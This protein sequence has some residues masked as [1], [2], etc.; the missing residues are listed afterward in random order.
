M[1]CKSKKPRKVRQKKKKKKKKKKIKYLCDVCKKTHPTNGSLRMH[2]KSRHE[3][4]EWEKCDHCDY[5]AK[6]I[7][8]WTLTWDAKIME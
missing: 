2:T 6:H 5:N 3:E 1:S 8:F 4:A 7:T